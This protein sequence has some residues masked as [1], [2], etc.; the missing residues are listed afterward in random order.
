MIPLKFRLQSSSL[1]IEFHWD[2]RDHFLNPKNGWFNEVAIEYAGGF[3]KGK[4]QF[5]QIY[6]QIIDTTGS[7]GAIT[8]PLL[9]QFVWGM[10]KGLEETVTERLSPSS[11]SMPGVQ[12]QSE[13]TRNGVWGPED[14]FGNH[15]G[16]VLFYFKCGT[17]FFQSISSS[18]VP[19]FLDTGSVWNKFSDIQ[20]VPPRLATGMGVRFDTP[21]GPARVDVGVP[22][23]REFKPLFYLQLGQAF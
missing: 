10:K 18:V 20:E 6:K 12:Q 15:R 3:L 11:V 1:G 4:N 14:E 13:D 21:L 8:G 22:L 17:S 16:D 9:V 7:F 5:F 19:Y 23:M 2:S